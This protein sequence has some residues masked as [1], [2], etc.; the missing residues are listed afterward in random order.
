MGFLGFYLVKSTRIYRRANLK[1]SLTWVGI[2]FFVAVLVYVI[3][4]VANDSN[5]CT[6]PVFWGFLGLGMAVNR[7]VVERGNLFAKADENG[8]SAE[9][10]KKADAGRASSSA[11]AAQT[12]SS[13]PAAQASSTAAAP[14]SSS[15]AA[16]Q[17]SSS[18]AA[19]S[20]SETAGKEA[21]SA[22]AAPKTAPASAAGGSGRK[23]SGRKKAR[24]KR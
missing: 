24:G 1:E 8:E 7:M 23:K 21:D 20:V 9:N 18:A 16:A 14:D 11:S 17:N 3:A 12:S 6:A 13:A 2:G 5:V 22:A 4:A 15:A 19:A 10:D